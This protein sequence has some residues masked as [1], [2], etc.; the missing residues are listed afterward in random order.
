MITSA[1]TKARRSIGTVSVSFVRGPLEKSN[2]RP[3]PAL[4]TAHARACV[5][6]CECECV[7]VA[8][9]H[10]TASHEIL[11]RVAGE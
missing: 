5:C 11:F 1:V 8:T 7:S 4:E 3:A 9:A 2:A 6:V 10:C